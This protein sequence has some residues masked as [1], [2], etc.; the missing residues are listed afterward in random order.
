MR[1]GRAEGSGGHDLREAQISRAEQGRAGHSSRPVHEWKIRP[2]ARGRAQLFKPGTSVSGQRSLSSV[3]E[4]GR[5]G[6]GAQHEVG[7]V[8]LELPGRAQQ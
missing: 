4:E 8:K 6:Q 3:A 1:Q 5:A 2:V 7:G